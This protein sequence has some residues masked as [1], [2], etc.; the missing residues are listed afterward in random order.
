[1]FFEFEILVDIPLVHPLGDQTQ[2]VLTQRR[3]E[4]WENVRMAEVFPR[5][6]FLAEPL[7]RTSQTGQPQSRR[8][9]FGK[10]AYSH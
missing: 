3:A 10:G 2:L 4:K 6:G 9:E 5:Y 1:M 7:P 8:H